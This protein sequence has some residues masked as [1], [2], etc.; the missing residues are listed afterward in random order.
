VNALK[1]WAER[2]E[3]K[4]TA[5]RIGTIPRRLEFKYEWVLHLAT[6]SRVARKRL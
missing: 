4:Q 5:W 1:E 3:G 6:G 2:Q